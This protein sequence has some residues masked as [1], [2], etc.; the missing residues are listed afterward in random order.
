MQVYAETVLTRTPPPPRPIKK[1]KILF[2]HIMEYQ[3]QNVL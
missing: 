3:I 2:F 1:K